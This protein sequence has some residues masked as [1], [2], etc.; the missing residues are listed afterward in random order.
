MNATPPES[1]L[2]RLEAII[3]ARR[4]L[5][6]GSSSYVRRLLDGGVPAIAAKISEEANET[7]AAAV[8]PDPAGRHHLIHEAADLTFHLLVLLASR[9]IAWADVEAELI[10]R[11]GT[12]GLVEKASRSQTQPPNPPD[13]PTPADP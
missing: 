1:I 9:D 8:E 2:A 7:V 3:A 10:R 5:P 11:F 12:S 4:A 13:P 6:P